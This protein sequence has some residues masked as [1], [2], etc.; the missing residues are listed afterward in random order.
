MTIPNYIRTNF[1]PCCERRR[2]GTLHL[3]NAWI[4]ARGSLATYCALS[5]VMERPTCSLLLGTWL[6]E[7]LMKPISLPI[8]TILT[9]F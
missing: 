1:R 8:Q 4:R 5:E 9:A 6:M 7:T 2:T 3:W